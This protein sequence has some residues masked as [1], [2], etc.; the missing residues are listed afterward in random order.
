MD[1]RRFGQTRRPVLRYGP[2]WHLPKGHANIRGPML[3]CMI[4]DIPQIYTSVL[5]FL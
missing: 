5:C 3:V 2:D 1:V 4:S